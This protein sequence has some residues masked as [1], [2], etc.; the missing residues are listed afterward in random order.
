MTPFAPRMSRIEPSPASRLRAQAQALRAAGRDVI[1]LTSGDL[2]FPSPDHVIA[3]AHAAMLR[4]DT[5]YSTVDGTAALKDAVRAKFRRE[6]DLDYNPDEVFVANG[7]TQIIFNA[8]FATVAAGDE[9][10]VPTPC[11]ASYLDQ[12]RLADGDPVPVPCLPQHGF[13][14]RPEDLE[15]A[16]TARTRWVVLNNP[17]NPTGAVYG[18]AELAGLAEVLLRHASVWIL[19]DDLYE[20][21]VFDGRRCATIAAVEPK[22]KARTLTAN[23]VAKTYAMMGWHIGYAGGPA[24]LIREMVKIQSQ[25]TAAASTVGQAAALAALTGPQELVAKRAAALAARREAFV[26]HLNRSPGLS[27]ALPEGTF[28]VF[29]SCAGVIGKR[30]PDGRQIETDR[31]V[32][33][34]LLDAA[35]TAVVPGDDCGLSPYFRGSFAL[36]PERLAEVGA[37]IERACAALHD[38]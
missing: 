36:P 34:Y 28:Y 17:V 9:V 26:A 4:G 1:V 38:R 23:G 7:S 15:A 25:S 31:D 18:R 2:D 14:L 10:I 8:F 33:A 19:A 16:I 11:W 21:I 13:R 20:H 29:V 37:R 12:V 3:A 24:A 22:L 6:N 32:A 35:D 27:C 5:K 30:G